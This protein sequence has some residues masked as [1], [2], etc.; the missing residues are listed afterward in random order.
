M[1]IPYIAFTSEEVPQLTWDTP[2]ALKAELYER[3]LDVLCDAYREAPERYN[4]FLDEPPSFYGIYGLTHPERLRASREIIDWVNSSYANFRWLYMAI[5]L[6]R[7]DY[8]LTDR[9]AFSATKHS[10]SRIADR[11]TA[12]GIHSG[13]RIGFPEFAGGRT[14]RDYRKAVAPHWDKMDSW[15]CGK[16]SWIRYY[17]RKYHAA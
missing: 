8:R 2:I 16:P 9:G 1:T 11:I 6:S 17:V 10:L 5:R 3:I 12:T 4:Y 7:D 13:H 15:S 14:H